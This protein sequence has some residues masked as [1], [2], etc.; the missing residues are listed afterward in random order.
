MQTVVVGVLG[1][2]AGFIAEHG[3][4]IQQVLGGAWQVLSG[5]V[6]TALAL[7]SGI[8]RTA[9][10]LI[11]GDWDGAWQAIQDAAAAFVEGLIGVLE[12]AVDLLGGAA[13]LMIAAIQGVWDSFTGWAGIGGGVIDGI[14]SG[15]TG[16]I[17]GLVAA[18]ANAAKSAL[19][20][21]KSA[22]GIASPS[23]VF[24]DEVGA[25]IP[26]GVADGIRSATPEA[27]N[28]LAD[29]ADKMIGVLSDGVDAFGKLGS[30]GGVSAEIMTRFGDT[31]AKVVGM[32]NV[33]A[34]WFKNESLDAAGE[35]ADTSSTILSMIGDAIDAFKVLPD[36]VVPSAAAVA[37]FGDALAKV[38]GW[39]NVIA[40]WFKG[41]PLA[42]AADFADNAATILDM[43]GGAVESLNAIADLVVPT[44]AAVTAFGLTLAQVVGVLAAVARLWQASAIEAAAIFSEAAGRAVAMIGGAVEAFAKLKDFETISQN[45][46]WNFSI[47]LKV[48]LQSLIYTMAA[49][50]ADAV[51]AAAVFGEGTGRAVGFIGAAVE[52][53]AK[54]K[55]FETISQNAIW[56]FSIVLKVVLQSL[57]YT[58]AAF[59]A[60][61]IA[62]AAVFGEGSGKAVA[63]IGGAVD[64][65]VKLKDFQTIPQSAIDAFGSALRAALTAM[66]AIAALWSADAIAA[67][68]TF[69]ESAGKVVSIIGGAVDGL[70]KLI[71]F[72]SPPEKTIEALRLSLDLALHAI[73]GLAASWDSAAIA[74]AATFASAATQIISM[75]SG[76]I[77]GFVKLTDL[78][79]AVGGD[80]IKQFG[81]A[82]RGILAQL[83]AQV[84]PASVDVGTQIVAGIARGL[85]TAAP[86]LAPILAAAVDQ[87]IGSAIKQLE[88]GSVTGATA[89]TGSGSRTTTTTTTTNHNYTINGYNQGQ[90]GDLTTAIRQM[91]L[92]QDA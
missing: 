91:Q 3:A 63:M 32:I 62:A 39:I 86:T 27:L 44:P 76:A 46:I 9:L 81:D 41:Q 31:L 37:Q 74:A 70:T 7:I 13:E 15:I 78:K 16:A 29:L 20:A 18:A 61:A 52:A 36:L 89:G 54:L 65:F 8:I 5:I 64:A 73:S 87:A 72:K 24:H 17:G 2:V 90:A 50:T 10:A 75:I 83:V 23:K 69:A 77:D 42:D 30:F 12:G 4:L 48:V 43:I 55:D 25:M 33:I 35:F 84:L 40:G 60:D 82:L 11:Q 80:V 59:T 92:L 38:V 68:A 56:N 21:A 71:E 45:A 49:F 47:V 57:I 79:S 22:L 28:A 88:D 85:Q 14:I 58:M 19:D 51:A 66:L 1:F 34:G 26:V 67:A 53:F 6:E